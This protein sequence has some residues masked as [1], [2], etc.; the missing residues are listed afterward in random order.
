MAARDNHYVR[1][2]LAELR[3]A[4]RLAEAH[5]R[6]WQAAYVG[7]LPQPLLDDLDLAES[8]S[9][10]EAT[11]GNSGSLNQVTLVAEQDGELV[12]FV[13]VRP[14][15]DAI[16]DEVGEV[17]A[18]YVAPSSWRIGVG[19]HLMTAALNR[20]VEFGLTHAVLWVLSSNERAI[21][22]YEATGWLADGA[23]KSDTVGGALV[24]EIR[25]ARP[26]P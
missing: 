25:M 23:S 1:V 15:Q 21:R 5:V 22:F 8:T 14:S 18:M 9:K 7:L 17:V 11:L 10:W 16:S 12:G 24:V 20:L 19:R 2:R 13:H 3:D 6:S 26:L 4:S